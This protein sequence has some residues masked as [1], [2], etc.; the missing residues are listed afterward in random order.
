MT[1]AVQF[2]DDGVVS[3]QMWQEE[4]HGDAALVGVAQILKTQ[5]EVIVEVSD[6]IIEGQYHKLRN[7]CQIK[8]TWKIVKSEL[9]QKHG[10]WQDGRLAD[11]YKWGEGIGL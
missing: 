10:W 6:S 7:L 2:I 1:N 9:L 5:V 11:I 8:T 3:V 4:G